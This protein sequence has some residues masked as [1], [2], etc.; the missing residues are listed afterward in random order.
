MIDKIK[1]EGFISDCDYCG[2]Q[3]VPAINIEMLVGDFENLFSIYEPTTHGEHYNY[4]LQC[5]TDNGNLLEELIQEDWQVFSDETN[6]N[7]L[8]FDI[9]NY[10]RDFE[11]SLDRHELYSK[12]S[13]AFTYVSSSE[14]WNE[15]SN[16]I[17]RRNRY[18]PE[19]DLSNELKMLLHNKK[20]LFDP[21]SQF[22]R[23][24]IGRYSVEEMGPPPYDKA[25]SGRV[26]PRGIPYLYVASDKYTCIAETRPWIG[27]KVTVA[28]IHAN[29]QLKIID[30]SSKEF[31][32][33][34]FLSDDLSQTIQAQELLNY[35]AYILTKPIDPSVSDIEYIPTQYLA[36]LIKNLGYDGLKYKSSLGSGVNYVFFYPDMFDIMTTHEFDVTAVG[37]DYN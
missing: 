14:M 35:L 23:A 5:A 22:Y 13:S 30:L 29:K 28:T 1:N 36:E 16:S 7:E 11:D 21:N 3:N 18:F 10:H 15:F 12:N 37:Y 34:P 19:Y 2:E 4:H 6:Q 26:N 33:S 31:L 25:T 24:R 9:L 8:L 17:K 32:S 27:A 20:V